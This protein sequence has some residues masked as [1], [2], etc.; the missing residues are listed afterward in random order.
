MPMSYINNILAIKQNEKDIKKDEI[1][2][3]QAAFNPNLI[4]EGRLAWMGVEDDMDAVMY[5]HVLNG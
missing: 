4:D 1:N 2:R 3:K 5:S